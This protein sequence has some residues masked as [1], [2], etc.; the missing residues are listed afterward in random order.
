MG[1][2]LGCGTVLGGSTAMAIDVAAPGAASAELGEIIVTA[3]KRETDLQHTSIS[4]GVV[5]GAEIES[6]GITQLDDALKNIVGVVITRTGLSAAPTIRGVGPTIET[7]T[8]GSAGVSSLLDGVYTQNNYSSRL[9]YYDLARVEVLRGPQGT[10]YGRNSEGGVVGLISNDPTHKFEGSASAD[11]GNYSLVNVTGMLNIPLSDTLALRVASSSVDRRGYLSN[12]QDDNRAQGARAKLLYQPSADFSL[13]VG[14]ETTHLRGEGPGTVAAF[15]NAP[16]ASAAF[17]STNPTG[18]FDEDDTYKLW[19]KM[20][21]DVGIGQL[22]LLPSYQYQSEP[23]QLLNNGQVTLLSTDL[24]STIERSVELRLTSEPGAKLSWAAGYYR[25]HY[26]QFSPGQYA[27]MV[28]ATG[29][30]VINPNP[31]TAADAFGFDD[32]TGIYGQ[33]MLPLSSQWRLIG[34]L[35]HSNDK[36][37]SL[38]E[39]PGEAPATLAEEVPKSARWSKTDWKAG[40][41]FDVT[42]KSMLYATVA[43]GYR[44]GGFTPNYP[45]PAYAPENLRSY[46]L[47]SKNQFL[48]NTLRVNAA[49]YDYNYQDYQQLT[50]QLC[51]PVPPCGAGAVYIV[52]NLIGFTSVVVNLPKVSVRGL[53]LETMYLPA[54]DDRLTA[55]LALQRSRIDSPVQFAPGTQLQGYS[56]PNS[57]KVTFNASYRHSFHVGN[58][59]ISPQIGPRYASSSYVAVPQSAVDT[60]KAWWQWDASLQFAP[61]MAAWSVNAYV[62]N[63]TDTVVKTNYIAA[64]AGVMTLQPPRTYGISVSARF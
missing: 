20:V 13:L 31:G 51:G 42:S 18:Q 63:A 43:T 5:S 54:P 52:P 21:A 30:V 27:T 11:I 25:Y 16:S 14:A 59:T 4:V 58:G 3:E 46:E 36:K 47:G 44:A 6:Q 57:P 40:T 9:G 62:R 61:D 50:F 39:S 38:L 12:G 26:H 56:L 53:E 41:E 48:D 49:V 34:G 28:D 17:T 1:A 22:T 64:G 23:K 2:L 7:T 8:G 33:A 19:A 60:Q 15:T 45:H 24:G 35:R 37:T 32:S 10:L 29:N 55:N